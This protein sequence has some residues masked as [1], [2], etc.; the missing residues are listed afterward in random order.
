MKKVSLADAPTQG[1]S[2]N[3]E[4]KKQTLIERGDVPHLLSFS[5]ARLLPGQ[6]ARAHAHAGMYEV[7]FVASGAGVL[8]VDDEEVMLEAGVCVTVEPG[9]RHEITNTCDAELVLIYFGVEA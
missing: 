4:I 6:V 5:R 1:V 7:F 3:P 2:H 9:E 8:Q